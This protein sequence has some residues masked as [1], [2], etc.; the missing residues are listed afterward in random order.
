VIGFVGRLTRDKGIRDLYHAFERLLPEFKDLQLLLVGDFETGDALP[1][2][3]IRQMHEHPQVF[4]TG[5]VNDTSAYYTLFDMFAFPSYREGFPNVV[6][7]ASACALPVVAYQST[8][9]VDAVL[10]GITGLLVPA[11]AVTSLAAAIRTYLTRPGLCQAHGAA[12]RR[13]VIEQFQP[14]MIWNA[15]FERYRQELSSRGLA[16]SLATVRPDHHRSHR[17]AA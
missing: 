8:G 7:E 17:R 11:G 1:A 6:L 10:D 14:E 13:R 2:D 3:V 15:L 4:V 5:Y 12:G 9:T 16:G